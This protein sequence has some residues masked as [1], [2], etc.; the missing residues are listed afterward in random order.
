MK[1]KNHILF[2]LIISFIV[3]GLMGGNWLMTAHA[4]PL[5]QDPRPPVNG[6]G[7]GGGGGGGSGSGGDGSG[8]AG[9]AGNLPV[10]PGVD[11]PGCASLTGQV[12][13]WGLGPQGQVEVELKTGSW[14]AAT[15]SASDGN[16]GLGGLGTGIAKLHVPVAP[17]QTTQPFIQNAGVYL[18]CSYNTVAN[19]AFSGSAKVN[20][21]VTIEMSA[22]NQTVVPDSNFEITLT[23][24][25]GLPTEISNV[26]VTDLMPKG[27]KALKVTSSVDPKDARIIDGGPD[28]QLVVVNLDKLAKRA[29][30]TIE[31]TVNADVDLLS[32][33]KIQNAATLFYRESAA[34]QAVL[35]FTVG[36]DEAPALAAAGADNS[37][38]DFVPPAE[39]PTTGGDLLNGQAEPASTASGPAAAGDDFVPP[40]NMPSTGGEIDLPTG[41]LDA[42]EGVNL[43]QAELLVK[44]E[45]GETNAI[46]RPAHAPERSDL[47]VVYNTP[48][49]GSPL[50]VAAAVLF[51]GFLV[52]GSGITLWRHHRMD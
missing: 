48:A 22:S 42:A 25:N 28:G 47:T 52:L 6:G 8:G 34:D 46:A 5:A 50:T 10:N 44:P 30:A 1:N 32:G 3:V 16:F 36:S 13:T 43:P 51:L 4:D 14:R 19:I 40:G 26:I 45:R 49:T 15:S 2:R 23:I 38:A 24:K 39:A 41:S 27:F 18:N 37:G 11:T 31:L 12:T 29:K 21:P 33:T 17:G 35:D 9:M 7:G 20:S